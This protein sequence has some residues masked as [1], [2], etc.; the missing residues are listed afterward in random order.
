MEVNPVTFVGLETA[1][2]KYYF[3]DFFRRQKKPLKVS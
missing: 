3:P 1:D 2:E